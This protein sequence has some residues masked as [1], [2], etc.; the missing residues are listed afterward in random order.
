MLIRMWLKPQTPS[1]TS[2]IWKLNRLK[3]TLALKFA[4]NFSDF[5]LPLPSTFKGSL[6]GLAG[7]QWFAVS[8]LDLSVTGLPY[9]VLFL[10]GCAFLFKPKCLSV[11]MKNFQK[12][13]SFDLETSRVCKGFVCCPVLSDKLRCYFCWGS[14]KFKNV[15]SRLPLHFLHHSTECSKKAKQTQRNLGKSHVGPTT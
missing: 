13:P 9:W 15:V 12:M 6:Q 4:R 10:Q 8:K 11:S 3:E 14:E 1:S 5:K 7:S 2:L